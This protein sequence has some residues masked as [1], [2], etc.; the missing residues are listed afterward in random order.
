MATTQEYKIVP[1]LHIAFS[2]MIHSDVHTLMSQY[3][4]RS[5]M[6]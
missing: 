3:A 5:K 2:M 1:R 6:R 4:T